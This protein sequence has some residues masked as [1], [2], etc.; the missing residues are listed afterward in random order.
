MPSQGNGGSGEIIALGHL[1]RP[2]SDS[3]ELAEKEGLAL[4]NGSP[5]AAALVADAALAAGGRLEVAYDAF[6]LSVEAFRAPLEAYD[7]V[8]ETLWGDAHERAAL[9]GLRARLADADP[10]R[11]P[12]GAGRLPHPA[13]RARP[14]GARRPRRRDRAARVSLASVTDNPVFVPP[15]DAHPRGRVL[16]TG[17]YH[18]SMSPQAMN[19]L[20]A[21]WADLAR[22]AERHVEHLW[23]GPGKRQ[24]QRVEELLSLLLMV[25]A[26]YTEEATAAAQPTLLVR[27]APSQNDI[28]SPA[29]LAWRRVEAAGRALDAVLAILLDRRHRA[30]A[31]GAALRARGPARTRRRGRRAVPRTSALASRGPRGD[32]RGDRRRDPP[33]IGP[34][35]SARQRHGYRS[36]SVQTPRDPTVRRDDEPT[37][38]TSALDADNPEPPRGDKGGRGLGTEGGV[39]QAGDQ[40]VLDRMPDQ[41]GAGVRYP[42]DENPDEE[43]PDIA[44]Q[45]GHVEVDPE[46][47][48]E[49]SPGAD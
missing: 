35:V 46:T 20:A 33:L 23:V 7:E 18:N 11:A 41:R 26:G 10:A 27:A 49:A 31:F 6:A 34:G 1:F 28:G 42:D 21:C 39:A 29:F 25:A 16:S 22:L 19:G 30:A 47:V 4:I 9:R 17:G 3:F 8:L 43:R 44:P 14:G 36:A 32:R 2:L 40:D 48:R 12:P 13:A 38:S 45:E 15:S 24:C 5:C 37:S